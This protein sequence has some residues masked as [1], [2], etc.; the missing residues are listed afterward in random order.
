MVDFPLHRRLIKRGKAAEKEV[1]RAE[2][3]EDFSLWLPRWRRY[4]G[5]EGVAVDEASV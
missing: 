2:E 1:K 3:N 4:R 5:V